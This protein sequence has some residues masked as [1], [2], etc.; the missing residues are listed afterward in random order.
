MI[1]DH[2]HPAED[3][4][5]SNN[6]EV[7]AFSGLASSVAW[8]DHAVF[9]ASSSVQHSLIAV[10]SEEIEFDL[11]SGFGDFSSPLDQVAQYASADV[12][13]IDGGGFLHSDDEGDSSD[14]F[15]EFIN[16]E[17]AQRLLLCP[18]AAQTAAFS[19]SSEKVSILLHQVSFFDCYQ[20]LHSNW[21]FRVTDSLS[22]FV[23]DD[24]CILGLGVGQQITDIVGSDSAAWALATSNIPLSSIAVDEFFIQAMNL[25]CRRLQITTE[26]RQLTE[27]AS[28]AVEKCISFSR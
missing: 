11:D 20:A 3:F 21:G 17:E 18:T 7:D 8:E 10:N 4:A 28:Q 1:L 6:P 2:S 12:I 13:V 27:C 9:S 5:V 25:A 16:H 14:E 19:S 24:S 26:K 22:S 15:G 23:V